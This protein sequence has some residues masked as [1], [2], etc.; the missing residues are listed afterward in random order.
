MEL[1]PFRV[2]QST[3]YDSSGFRRLFL[4]W[5]KRHYI[6]CVDL[7]RHLA[8]HWRVVFVALCIGI[9][10][11]AVTSL[12]GSGITTAVVV[13]LLGAVLLW[14]DIRLQ[15][16]NSR[17][18]AR[19]ADESSEQR[20][21]V[22]R[23]DQAEQ[24][25]DRLD[26]TVN[27]SSSQL[28][29][30][31]TRLEE[32]DGHVE[33]SDERLEQQDAEVRRHNDLIEQFRVQ[34]EQLFDRVDRIDTSHRALIDRTRRFEDQF[35]TSWAQR[36]RWIEDALTDLEDMVEE[37]AL[38][39]GLTPLDTGE[40]DV[41]AEAC[42]E[43][44]TSGGSHAVRSPPRL[45]P[46][47]LYWWRH[48][49]GRLPNF[50][51]E[52]SSII[53]EW[54]TGRRVVHAS[55]IRCDLVA[56]G[57]VLEHV[58][59]SDRATPAPVWGA[60]FIAAESECRPDC[61]VPYAVRGHLSANRIGGSTAVGDPGL[62]A[63]HL[64]GTVPKRF[65]IGI[66]PH[67]VDRDH[68]MLDWLESN[69]PHAVVISPLQDPLDAIAQI[70]ACDYVISSSLHGLVVADSLGVPNR[71]VTMSDNV[72]GAGYK[73]RDHLSCFGLDD[74]TPLAFHNPTEAAVVL[75]GDWAETY[76]RSG[77][78]I[79]TERLISSFPSAL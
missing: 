68:P 12:V 9:A 43:P 45:R 57:S 67:F 8:R 64:V 26:G 37:Y 58:M 15:T 6:L 61:V 60:G 28:S 5:A 30:L 33:R 70:A 11:A 13:A 59:N 21:L 35:E 38:L 27:D 24:T 73:F 2:V 39:G 25:V 22:R 7:R 14:F 51:D 48:P 53:V 66:V 41:D 54:M 29:D 46:I 17:L 23:V 44:S 3:R 69:V 56:V 10:A 50:G 71:W 72:I 76:D 74:A 62:L 20:A 63:R 34:H 79:L 36:L 52:L 55:P 1:A 49:S 19:T 40:P 47:R 18:R 32:I 77:L 42:N 65:S 75:E 16:L 31:R 4:A 78:N